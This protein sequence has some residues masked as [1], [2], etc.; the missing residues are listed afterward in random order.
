[1]VPLTRANRASNNNTKLD[2]P[3]SL[4]VMQIT[5]PGDIVPWLGAFQPPPKQPE[6]AQNFVEILLD[7]R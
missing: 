1:M 5:M 2:V 7:T 4:S 6:S 3:F